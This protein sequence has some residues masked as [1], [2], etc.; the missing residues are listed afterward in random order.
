M[1]VIAAR[2]A[3]YIALRL[4]REARTRRFLLLICERIARAV[5]SIGVIAVAARSLGANDFGIFV[6]ALVWVSIISTIGGLSVDGLAFR[7]LFSNEWG[8]GTVVATAIVVRATGTIAVATCAI[9]VLVLAGQS[10]RELLT[11]VGVLSFGTVVQS[12]ETAELWFQARETIR[13]VVVPRLLFFIAS[14]LVKLYALSAGMGLVVLAVLTAMEF[15]GSGLLHAWLLSRERRRELTDLAPNA[16]LACGL[17]RTCPPLIFS[18]LMVLVYTRVPA[19]VLFG[20]WG[21]RE[22]GVFA[23]ANRLVESVLF[24]PALLNI[25]V[26]PKLL[27]D[28]GIGELEYQRAC[29]QFLGKMAALGAAIGFGFTI[30]APW[31]IAAVYGGQYSSSVPILLVLAWVPLLAFLG[32]ARGSILLNERITKDQLAFSTI[33]AFTSIS[34]CLLLVPATGALGAALA[35]LASQIASVLLASFVSPTSRRIGLQAI[36]VVSAFAHLRRA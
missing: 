19:I 30:A 6:Y 34:S 31:L 12:L 36:R 15:A 9:T 11:V 25:V 18:S 21:E 3:V 4:L 24:M 26:L 33:G 20:V 17:L 5:A 29:V 16:R 35:V 1:G 27:R 2:N 32:S 13:V 8:N 28:R 14:N 10:D 7:E 22:L 23:A